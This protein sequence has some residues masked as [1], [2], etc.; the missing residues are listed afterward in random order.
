MSIEI[1]ITD[2]W[3]A[4]NLNWKLDVD[5]TGLHVATSEGTGITYYLDITNK[6]LYRVTRVINGNDEAFIY[7]HPKSVIAFIR[8]YE[9]CTLVHNS[10]HCPRCDTTLVSHSQH[11]FKGCNCPEATRVWIDGGNAFCKRS[12]AYEGTTNLN[13]YSSEHHEVLREKCCR[14]G[15]GIDGRQP[16]TWVKIKDINDNWLNSLITYCED[17]GQYGSIHYL[18]YLDELEYRKTHNITITGE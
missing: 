4:Y 2:T 11:D 17:L 8:R 9:D 16:L 14:G 6:G 1:I 10:L 13:L 3:E 15:R 18:M 12:G 5:S 7:K